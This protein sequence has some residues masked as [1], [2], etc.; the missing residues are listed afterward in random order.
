[1]TSALVLLAVLGALGG[2]DTVY[3]HEWRARLPAQQGGLLTELK[4]HAGRDAVYAV[5]FT[6]LPWV[7]WQGRAATGLA[8]L[9][10]IEIAITMS[11][12]VLEDKVRKPL[13]GVFPGERVTHGLMAIIYGAMLA[14]LAPVMRDWWH[15]PTGLHAHTTHV[16]GALRIGLTVMGVG[17]ALSGVRDF[18]AAVGGR[19]GSWPWASTPA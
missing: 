12:F 8:L 2:F 14:R 10:A 4:L 9:F 7:A 15:Q 11:D 13:G 17:I 18:Y 16:P 1:M 5:I 3:F 6:T 19:H